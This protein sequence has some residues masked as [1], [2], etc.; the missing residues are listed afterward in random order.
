MAY[1]YSMVRMPVT[2]KINFKDRASKLS[3]LYGRRIPLTRLFE[4]ISQQE[5]I[6]PIEFSK[7][8]K[9]KKRKC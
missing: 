2:A 6:E 5:S 9:G 8:I 1:K 3:K 4:F 7:F